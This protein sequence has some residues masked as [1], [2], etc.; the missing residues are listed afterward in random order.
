MDTHDLLNFA[1]ATGEFA[2]RLREMLWTAYGKPI[3]F[4]AVVALVVVVG[5]PAL[6]FLRKLVR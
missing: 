5:L 1:A 2:S 6:A 4:V 3:K